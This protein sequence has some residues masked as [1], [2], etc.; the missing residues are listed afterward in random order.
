MQCN[1]FRNVFGGLTCPHERF[2]LVNDSITQNLNLDGL[3]NAEMFL[4][5]LPKSV[6]VG[7]P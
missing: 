1:E 7:C 4:Q 3:E 2:E 6:G 5:F